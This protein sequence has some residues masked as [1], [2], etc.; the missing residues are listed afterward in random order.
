MCIR[1]RTYNT[2]AIYSQRDASYTQLLVMNLRNFKYIKH[3]KGINQRDANCTPVV[4]V[5]TGAIIVDQEG[6]IETYSLW[7]STL[8]TSRLFWKRETGRG[9]GHWGSFGGYYGRTFMDA[10]YEGGMLCFVQKNWIVLYSLDDEEATD[11]IEI[12]ENCLSDAVCSMVYDYKGQ[13]VLLGHQH[14]KFTVCDLMTGS[15]KHY[16]VF[17][18]IVNKVWLHV[19]IDKERG[20][21]CVYELAD[22]RRI[23]ALLQYYENVQAL[24]QEKRPDFS[25]AIK[26][27]YK[28]II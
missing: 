17:H 6:G 16:R 1:D 24:E 20:D 9:S 18:H 5:P 21:T 7:N 22:D 13:K 3:A 12:P 11:A 15:F 25:Y 23:K 14:V 8:K 2:A 4:D 28:Y 19:A 10:D 27:S 26:Q